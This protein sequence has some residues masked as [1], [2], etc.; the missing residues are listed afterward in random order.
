MDNFTSLKDALG[1]DDLGSIFH[2]FSLKHAKHL[3]EPFH[4]YGIN[5]TLSEFF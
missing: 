1:D 5:F 3:W 2:Y 4:M